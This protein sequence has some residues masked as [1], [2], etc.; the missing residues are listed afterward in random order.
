MVKAVKGS[1]IETEPSIKEVILK[2]G[3]NEKFVIE[4]IDDCR[5]FITQEA[6]AGIKERVS[7]IMSLDKEPR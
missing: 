3:E 7:K 1:L 2:L 4:E 5:I 6:A